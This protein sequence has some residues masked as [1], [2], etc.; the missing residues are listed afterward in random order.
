MSANPIPKHLPLADPCSLAHDLLND[1][2]IIVGECDLLDGCVPKG[3]AT[4][5]LR[6]IRAAARRMAER[7]AS[8][9]CPAKTEGLSHT[10]HRLATKIS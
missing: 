7:I 6:I 4:D 5:R 10:Q 2:A 9:P 3:E 8:R 1:L